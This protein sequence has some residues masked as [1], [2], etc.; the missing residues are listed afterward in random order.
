[1]GQT[2]A[3]PSLFRRAVNLCT[4]FSSELIARLLDR[5]PASVPIPAGAPETMHPRPEIGEQGGLPDQ[6]G[7]A[8][9][10][11]PRCFVVMRH[12]GLSLAPV[13]SER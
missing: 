3:L 7:G 10:L 12:R 6:R 8:L 2:P 13:E 4:F 9:R 5:R 1:M 11:T